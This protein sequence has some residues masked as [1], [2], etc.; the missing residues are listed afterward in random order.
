METQIISM[1][2][3]LDEAVKYIWGQG[4]SIQNKQPV[5]GGDINE[6]YRL[7]LSNEEEAFLKINRKAG[8]IFFRAEANGLT[9]M[10][11]A[12]A[13]VPKVLGYGEGFLLLVYEKSSFKA[14][15]YGT[16]LGQML[17]NMH[18][19]NT[20]K[21]VKG[22]VFGFYEDNFI[23]TTVQINSPKSGWVK[24]FRDARLG[25]QMKMADRYF[26]KE[27]RKRCKLLLDR[28][29]DLLI[30]P[31]FPSLLHGDLWSGNAMPDRK[32]K[33]MLIDPAVYVGHHEADLAMTE[34]FGG[35]PSTF[36]NAY[37]EIIPKESGY[38]DRRDIYNL[39]HL[40]NHL[41]LFGKSYLA[42]VRRILRHYVG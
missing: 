31:K 32:G 36:Y 26:D 13:N 38:E 16:L 7:L 21:L 20:E 19:S 27:D 1:Y 33:P 18:L 10:R 22:N 14:N 30:E 35:F 5:S 6:A 4:V 37:Y 34:L 12:G 3:N 11:D 29:G 15:D 2:H 17:F 39:Y 40:L 24:F 25:V 8:E 41:N 42:S 9:A 23:G 28:L